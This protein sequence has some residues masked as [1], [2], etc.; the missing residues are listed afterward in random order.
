MNFIIHYLSPQRARAR[1]GLVNS[2]SR[3]YRITTF[4]IL[5]CISLGICLNPYHYQD[6]KLLDC[7]MEDESHHV[8]FV[9]KSIL[10]AI[11][12]NTSFSLTNLETDLIHAYPTKEQV[13]NTMQNFGVHLDDK[14]VLYSQPNFVKHSTRVFHILKAYGFTDVTVLDGGLLKYIQDGYPTA[15]GV[16]YTGPVSQ[17]EDLDNP[18]LYLAQ[19]KEV[20]EFAEGK[21]PNIQLIDAR[22]DEEYYGNDPHLPS[23]IRQGH[24]PGSIHIPSEEFL[25][26]DD[27]FLKPP[28]IQKILESK[29]VDRNKDIIVM[30][31]TGLKATVNYFALKMV[32]Y[33]NVRL[34]DGSWVEYEDSNGP[35]VYFES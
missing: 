28:E 9:T 27:T 5:I 13:I 25:N 21:N 18:F 14:I 4:Q 6:I 26:P 15:P 31:R 35:A 12:L 17:I 32:G 34:Y 11:Y 7:T 10:H 22:D 16:G 19:M 2:A 1:Q 33:P 23:Y 24:V 20:I 3:L 29:G 8:D 30:C